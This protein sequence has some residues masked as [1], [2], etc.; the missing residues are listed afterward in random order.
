MLQSGM[1]TTPPLDINDFDFGPDFGPMSSTAGMTDMTISIITQEAMF[2]HKKICDPPAGRNKAEHWL[3]KLDLVR[4]LE[5]QWKAKYAETVQESSSL[6]RLAKLVTGEIATDLHLQLRRPPFKQDW[7]W[8]P[9]DDDFNILETATKVLEQNLQLKM[10]KLA[11]FAW[12]NWIKWYALALVLAELC[13]NPEPE[14]AERGYSIA[15]KYYKAYGPLLANAESEQIWRPISKLMHRV[16]QI[17]SQDPSTGI[18]LD[19]MVVS[20]PDTSYCTIASTNGTGDRSVPLI[21][22]LA[23]GTSAFDETFWNSATSHGFLDMNQQAIDYS[24]LEAADDTAWQNWNLFLDDI[25][26]STTFAQ[27]MEDMI[28]ET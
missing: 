27:P 17:R 3:Y 16:E 10:P 25:N 13:G 7:I 15:K 12:K 4:T 1:F 18:R 11:Q 2:C 9:A 24:A 8:V 22:E 26:T 28:N 23:P 14:K 21:P 20:G 6:H 19:P 5:R